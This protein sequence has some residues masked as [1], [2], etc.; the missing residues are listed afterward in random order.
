LSDDQIIEVFPGRIEGL[1]LKVAKKT[2]DDSTMADR[3]QSLAGTK[4][5]RGLTPEETE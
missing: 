2:A 5:A 1:I 3:Y 4:Q